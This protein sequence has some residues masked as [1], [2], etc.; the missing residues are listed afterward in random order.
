MS[1]VDVGTATEVDGIYRYALDNVSF[2]DVKRKVIEDLPGCADHTSTTLA[3]LVL[4]M[5]ECGI[6]Y[7]EFVEIMCE[8]YWSTEVLLDNY[9]WFFEDAKNESDLVN[10]VENMDNNEVILELPHVFVDQGSCRRNHQTQPK[11]GVLRADYHRGHD[12]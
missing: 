4:Y 10:C 9:Y 5:I 2:A 3:V 7:D 1:T 12:T 11:A 8:E 6:T